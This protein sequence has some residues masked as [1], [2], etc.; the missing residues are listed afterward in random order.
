M[1]MDLIAKEWK[2]LLRSFKFALEGFI[3]VIKNERNMQ[4]H[5]G[6]A[7]IVIFMAYFF[8]VSKIE[9]IILLVLIGMVLSLET[10]NTAVERIVDLITEDYHPLAKKAKDVSAAAVFL[11]SLMAII[12]GL[13]IFY[14]PVSD[15]IINVIIN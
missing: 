8:S 2:R 3:Y 12:I 15:F 5:I 1:L 14:K 6:I 7:I 4:I 11:F 13:T 9:W 10:L